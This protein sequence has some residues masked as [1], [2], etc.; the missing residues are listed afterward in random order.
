MRS[1]LAFPANLYVCTA[2]VV[3]TTPTESYGGPSSVCCCGA[4]LYSVHRS[5]PWTPPPCRWI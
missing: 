1:P 4:C 3:T 5:S 2:Q